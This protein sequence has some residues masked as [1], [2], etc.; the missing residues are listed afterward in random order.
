MRTT[1]TMTISLPPGMARQLEKVRKQE[2]R[3]RSE[4]MREALR[5]YFD[6]RVP[7]VTPTQTELTAIRRGRA[8]FRRGEYVSLD[9]LLH[10]LDSSS[11]QAGGKG[12]SK[13]TRTGSRTRESRSA[14]NAG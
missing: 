3:T 7:E 13:A 12:P 4:L 9:Q 8:A 10:D 6:S 1:E 14:R 2:H 5:R 11:H